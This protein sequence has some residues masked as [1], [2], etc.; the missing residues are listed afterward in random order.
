MD[1]QGDVLTFTVPAE[2]T[3]SLKSLAR[4]HSCSP[5]MLLLAAFQILLMRYTGQTDFGIGTPVA[6]RNHPGLDGIIGFF[7]NTLV[8]RARIN[9]NPTFTEHLRQTRDRALKAFT[10]QDIPFGKLVEA[11]NP[12][13]DMSRNPIFQVMFAYQGERAP[14]PTFG[15]VFGEQL[16]RHDGT[17]KFDLSLSM[18][19]AGDTLRGNFEFAT[20]LFTHEHVRQMLGHWLHLLAALS[21][22]PGQTVWQLPLFDQAEHVRLLHDP[23]T[24]TANFPLTERVDQLIARQAGVASA[25]TCGPAR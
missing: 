25:A 10:H 23:L 7:V 21:N 9:G 2:L 12:P 15:N 17:S 22:D 1:L 8:L 4:T 19:E 6:G 16:R 5:F 14:V 11:L 13:R 18:A 24:G 3:A 20:S